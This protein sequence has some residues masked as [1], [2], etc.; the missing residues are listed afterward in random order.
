MEPRAA[1]GTLGICFELPY[2]LEGER[3]N[4]CVVMDAGVEVNPAVAKPIRAYV[5]IKYKTNSIKLV[6]SVR[7]TALLKP[8]P[9]RAISSVSC[10]TSLKLQ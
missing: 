3:V 2:S 10:S 4:F 5:T 1:D 7:G 6:L 8:I 9:S